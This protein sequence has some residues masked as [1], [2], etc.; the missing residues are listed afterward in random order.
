[1]EIAI[2]SVSLGETSRN[3]LA[4]AI[5]ADSSLEFG[6]WIEQGTFPT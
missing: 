5:A 4:E 3:Q 1:M 6:L 2:F